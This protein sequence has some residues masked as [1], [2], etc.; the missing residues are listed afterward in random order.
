VRA[1]IE[2]I[3]LDVVAR[4]DIDGVHF[5]DYFYPHV[6]PGED[7]GDEETYQ[8]DGAAQFPDKGDWRRDNVNHLIQEL[9]GRISGAKPWVAFGVSPFGVWRDSRTDPSGSDTRAGIHDF[10]DLYADTRTWI[11]NDWI[12]YIA[13][14]LYW[15]I[16]FERAAYD[17]LLP[18]W[19]QEVEGSNVSLYIGQSAYRIGDGANDAAWQDLEEMPRHL[20]LNQGY[21][22]VAGD[23]Y[24]R[25]GSVLANPL[26]FADRLAG[27]LY[28]YHALV[29]V[30]PSRPGAAPASPAVTNADTAEDGSV[31]LSWSGGADAAYY[32][33]YRIDGAVDPPAVDP[34]TLEDPANLLGT[35]RAEENSNPDGTAA[36]VQ[37]FTDHTAVAGQAYTYLMTAVDRGHNESPPGA[38]AIG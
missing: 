31:V 10:D 19:A 26:G 4:Y 18:W 24:F 14:Q 7:F 27:D 35:A 21:P 25:A 38:I 9:S 34:C 29:P 13:P 37:T 12:D 30:R 32:A 1:F 15:N 33:V 2:D 36:P 8:H 5:D 17:V 3:V 22:A 6:A 16:G 20:A 28:R 11:R 23:I